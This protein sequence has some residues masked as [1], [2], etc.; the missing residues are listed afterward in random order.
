MHPFDWVV[1]AGYLLWIVYDGLKRSKGTDKVDGYFLANRSLPWWA[2][3]LS[4]MATQMSAVTLVGTTGQAYATGLRFIQ[5]YFGLPLAM[6]ILSLTVV[7]FFTRARVY[8]AYEYLERRFDAK[9]R[10]LASFLFLMGR[11]FSL[12][13]TLA[14]PAVVMSAILGWTLPVT[15]LVISVPMILYTTLGGVQAVAWTDV[16]QMFVVVGGMSAAIVVLLYGILQNVDFTQALHLAGAT[17][18]LR[19]IDFKFD[20][21]E[22]YTFWSGMIGGLFLMLAYFG[23]DQSQ[24]QRYLT[25]K[26][27]DEARHSLLMSGYVKI[28]LQLLV[29][30]SGVLVFVFYL[31]ETPPML[32]NHAYDAAVAA[33]PAAGE[34][35]VLEQRFAAALD[36]RRAA[37]RRGDRDGFVSSDERVRDIRTEAVTLVKRVSGDQRYNDVNYVFP[38]FVTTRLPT[39]LVGLMI[40]AIFVAA[41]S[42]SGGELNALAT[43]TIIDFYRRH[44]VKQA[45]ERHYLNVSKAATSFWGLFACVVAMYAANQGSLIEVVNRYGSFFYGSL[46]GVFILAILSRRATARGAFWGLIAGMVVVLTVAFSPWTREIAFLWHNLIGAVVVVIVGLAISA[47]DPSQPA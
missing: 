4:V 19:A 36:T 31:F 34:Y 44:F 29:L 47:V 37:A 10:S 20:P 18:R 22:T 7:P 9:T 26:S 25:A 21:R 15:V 33:S 23:C 27:I 24:V 28:P 42:A 35:A 17:G 30:A 1:V 3:G 2:V 16:K 39:G 13:V 38:T 40:A 8:T 6:I 46:L 43:A 45:S 5:F 11:A 14:A 12:G 41:M 32:F